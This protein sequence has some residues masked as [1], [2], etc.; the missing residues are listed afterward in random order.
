MES[1]EPPFMLLGL[2]LLVNTIV[3]ES[4]SMS[5]IEG[6]S[7]A[8]SQPFSRSTHSWLL[9]NKTLFVRALCT[10]YYF[11]HL[12][13]SESTSSHYLPHIYLHSISHKNLEWHCVEAHQTQN[14]KIKKIKVFFQVRKDHLKILITSREVFESTC[15]LGKPFTI[16][17]W[18]SK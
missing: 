4:L 16:C 10:S 6:W 18:V 15:C 11:L 1:F 14:K 3:V 7:G 13:S 9:A 5:V 8:D 17:W 2:T 12:M